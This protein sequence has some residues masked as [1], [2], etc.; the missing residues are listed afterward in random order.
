MGAKAL[1][2]LL[3]EERMISEEDLMLAHKIQKQ[4]GGALLTVLI[5][6]GLVDSKKV[7]DA[8]VKEYKLPTVDLANFT[9]DP[10]IIKL[11]SPQICA[12]NLVLPIQKAGR[13]LVVAFADPSNDHII[14]NL[15]HITRCRIEPVITTQEQLKTAFEKYFR[16]NSAELL[17]DA[18]DSFDTEL[19]TVDSKAELIDGDDVGVDSAPVIKFVNV[20]LQEA[21]LSGTSDI[22]IEPYEK[23]FRVRF[24]IDGT[25]FE[26]MSPPQGAAASIASRIKIL[27][28]MDIAEKRRPQ[29]GRIKVKMSNGK[30]VDFRVNCVP[31]LFGEKIVM[32]ILDKSNLQADLMD[33]GMEEHDLKKLKDALKQPQGM[34]LIT[35]PTGSGKSTTVY[36]ALAELNKPDINISTAE[37]PVEYNLEGINQVQVQPEIGFDF[38]AAL[39]AFLR[40]DPEIIMVG[41]IRDYETGAIAYKAASTGHMVVSTLHTNGAPA[42]VSRLLDMGIA[43]YVVAESTSLV[44]AQ[45]LIKRNCPKCTKPK[46][47]ED[48]VL[49]ELGVPE[50][51]LADYAETARGKGCEK[52]NKTGLSGRMAIFEVLKIAT[53]IK[54]AILAGKPPLEIK[55]AAVKTGMTSL[56]QSA[57]LKLKRGQTTVEQVINA[58]V[59]DDDE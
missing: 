44:V 58:S 10:E 26:K 22:H 49:L 52:C 54:E 42:T 28:S 11:I 43:P 6:N 2:N 27:S 50:N 16:K 19:E 59:A 13:T 32:R 17:S 4:K 36:S 45:R 56:R 9:I 34:I 8:I 48:K 18:M 53:D 40:Q 25:L 38:P 21:I 5:G 12:K 51:E 46:K 55:K 24:R 3:L 41:E 20:M 1:S 15:A 37:D 57:L 29:D 14:E 7:A 39:R 33:L 47:V 35:G 23:R 31:T 30:E